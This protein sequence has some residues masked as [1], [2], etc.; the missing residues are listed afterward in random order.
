MTKVVKLNKTNETF[1][2]MP[3]RDVRPDPESEVMNGN[4]FVAFTKKDNKIIFQTPQLLDLNHDSLKTKR[5]EPLAIESFIVEGFTKEEVLSTPPAFGNITPPDL[6]KNAEM[7]REFTTIVMRGTD[8]RMATYLAKAPEENEELYL[9]V[10]D[11][12]VAANIIEDTNK[13]S[14]EFQN[15]VVTIDYEN[16]DMDIAFQSISKLKTVNGALTIPEVNGYPQQIEFA[17]SESL[18]SIVVEDEPKELQDLLDA[19]MKLYYGSANTDINSQLV[20]FYFHYIIAQAAS[21]ELSS[22]TNTK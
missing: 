10:L 9:A 7:R 6:V 14:E 8:G 12:K 16:L 13:M 11:Y 22:T 2:V 15:F 21:N 5:L 3:I 18:A 19:A 1:M 4:M 20:D 17:D